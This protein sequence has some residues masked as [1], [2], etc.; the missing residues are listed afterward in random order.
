M[1]LAALAIA[2]GV[3]SWF[4]LGEAGLQDVGAAPVVEG[5]RGSD[6][7]EARETAEVATEE[8]MPRARV[9]AEQIGAAPE[10]SLPPVQSAEKS[11]LAP[12]WLE[13]RTSGVPAPDVVLSGSVD[14]DA[15]MA[16][17]PPKFQVS[18]DGDGMA[19]VDIG[20]LLAS[21][22]DQSGGQPARVLRIKVISGGLAP[23]AHE[24]R[25]PD[26]LPLARPATD[27]WIVSIELAEAMQL[28]GV[29]VD[30]EG[31]PITGATAAVALY[32]LRD[33]KP[34]RQFAVR[35]RPD[36]RGAFTL[37][38][39]LVGP[40]A[41]LAMA[42]GRRP[43]TLLVDLRPGANGD[44]GD[45]QMDLGLAIEGTVTPE[46][47]AQGEGTGLASA[48]RVRCMLEDVSHDVRLPYYDSNDVGFM[49]WESGKFE[50]VLV[51]ASTQKGGRFRATGLAP[52]RYTVSLEAE[53]WDA[54]LSLPSTEGVVP[55]ATL[56]LG[57]AGVHVVIAL[58]DEEGSP[59]QAEGRAKAT[60]AWLFRRPDGIEEGHKASIFLAD[61]LHCQL[62]SNALVEF[63]LTPKGYRTARLEILTG[64]AGATLERSLTLVQDGPP[65]PLVDV[66]F[67][68]RGIHLEDGTPI[69]L[70]IEREGAK[71]RKERLVTKDQRVRCALKAGD[72]LAEL[73]VGKD[74]FAPRDHIC[75]VRRP[76]V[77]GPEPAR[78]IIVDLER[79]GVLILDVTGPDGSSP[80]G[81][82][83]IR[84]PAGDVI[85]TMFVV[86]VPDGRAAAHD[87]LVG[88]G[89]ARAAHD[90]VPGV[91]RVTF[92][93]SGFEK[94]TLDVVI[95]AGETTEHQIEL[96][97]K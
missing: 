91:Y 20:P 64:P 52:D 95:R 35:T 19:R 82:C 90:F 70:R 16:V 85:S 37:S 40:Y 72:V 97:P 89:K 84:S 51:F 50:S 30:Q 34:D 15:F 86:K 28:S 22:R 56:R 59:I 23:T 88:G 39:E 75:V 12:W 63:E 60:V 92:R 26:P 9:E 38:T 1:A 49:A 76:L 18:T 29:L 74:R 46:A 57:P 61:R 14:L 80:P 8:L 21:V 58:V 94:E 48:Q 27:P 45:V 10:D 78:E 13:I 43:A 25:L 69:A 73:V 53:D 4:L 2:V 96:R 42:P 44:L 17:K 33:G 79:G 68:L 36:T 77:L 32:R 83:E 62:P 7:F 6:E 65:A 71:T 93:A 67:V 31:L 54:P 24:V 11:Q 87:F 3:A 66:T 41:L 55:P 81:S 5:Q 47:L